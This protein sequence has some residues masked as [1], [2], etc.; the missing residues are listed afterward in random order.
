MPGMAPAK[1]QHWAVRIT[2]SQKKEATPHW[3]EESRSWIITLSEKIECGPLVHLLMGHETGRDYDNC[4]DGH[5]V[6]VVMRFRRGG[7]RQ[8]MRPWKLRVTAEFD[9]GL[10]E[11]ELNPA[12]I[13][14]LLAKPTNP[15][16]DGKAHGESAGTNKQQMNVKR[17]TVIR[18]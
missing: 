13:M 15:Q 14:A 5:E 17:T 2:R 18:V 8:G 1:V 9:G 3:D 11:V 12:D 4:T 6:T 7:Y 16:G 10:V